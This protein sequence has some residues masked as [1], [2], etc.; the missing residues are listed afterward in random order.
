M[1]TGIKKD[2]HMNIE[3]GILNIELGTRNVEF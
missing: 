3:Q 1:E 2:E